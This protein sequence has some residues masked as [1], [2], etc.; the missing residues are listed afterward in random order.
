M[1]VM[2][3]PSGSTLVDRAIDESGRVMVVAGRKALVRSSHRIGDNEISE[4]CRKK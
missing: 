3:G 2:E 1:L 4:T